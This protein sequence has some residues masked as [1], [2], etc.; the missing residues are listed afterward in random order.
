MEADSKRVVMAGSIVGT[1]PE[2]R[3]E[4]KVE[5]R[6]QRVATQCVCCGGDDIVSSPAIL[7]PFVADRVFGWKPVVI[8]ESWG[9]RT[10]QNG[11]AYSICNTLRCVD[12]GHLF[13]DIRFSDEEMV[14]LYN[15]YREKQ[16]TELREYYEPGYT[17]RNEALKQPIGYTDLI[18]SFLEPHLQ[19]PLTVLD[20]GGDTGLNTPFKG[21][22]IAFDIYDISD[23]EVEP[24]ARFVTLDQAAALKYRLIVCSQLLEHVPYP[25]EVLLAARQTMDSESVL[26]IELPYEEVMRQ[27][28]PNA[29]QHKRHWHEHVNFY[30]EE[31]LEALIVNCGFQILAKNVLTTMVAGSGVHIFQVACKL[32]GTVR[33]NI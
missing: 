2:T 4:A 5:V 18:E 11:H 13:C 28:L 27:T 7:M 31:S 19:F 25:F 29:E 9:L 6:R 14:S 8:D 20:W 33:F 1:S 10:I 32:G 21:K 24:G 23:K 17:A 30:S 15:K 12:C 3:A 26:Y 16:Y 22:N